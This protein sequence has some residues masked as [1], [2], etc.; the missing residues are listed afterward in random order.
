MYLL[1]VLKNGKKTYTRITLLEIVLMDLSKAFDCIP[2]DLTIAK[3]AA[4]EF[5][6]NML[7]YIYTVKIV[8]PAFY[9][10]Q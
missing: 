9:S 10:I 2:H 8:T 6:K 5:N 1:D 3:L 7:C 4:Y